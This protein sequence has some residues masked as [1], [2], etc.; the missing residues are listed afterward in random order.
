MPAL[1]V[2]YYYRSPR[3]RR[4]R[5]TAAALAIDPNVNRFV[6]FVI[7]L[8]T[9]ALASEM[10]DM[11]EWHERGLAFSNMT[12]T[13]FFLVEM[14]VKLFGLGFYGYIEDRLN[15]FWAANKRLEISKFKFKFPRARTYELISAR[16]RL[17]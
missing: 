6:T 1:R 5:R 10:Q 2:Q 15:V 12:F 3:Y 4:A 17:S 16:S 9:I 14:G 8:N 13:L 7:I 11:T